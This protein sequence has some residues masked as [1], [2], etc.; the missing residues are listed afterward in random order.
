[1]PSSPSASLY[2]RLGQNYDSTRR[3]DPFIA[4]RLVHHLSNPRDG[5]ILDLACGTG[6]Y[7]IE[8]AKRGLIVTGVDNSERMIETASQKQSNVSWSLGDAE[9]LPFEDETFSGAICALAIHH[10][11]ALDKPFQEIFRVM[12]NGQFVIFTATSGQM[13][14]YWLNDYFPE[15]MRKSVDQMPGLD[16]VK[17]SLSQAGF[18]KI[19]TEIYEIQPDLRDRFLYSGKHNPGL[20]LDP[21]IR[22]GI[23][24][25]SNFANLDEVR[26]GC[27]RLEED[28]ISGAIQDVIKKFEHPNGDYLFVIPRKE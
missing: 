17:T 22:A 16:Q 4:S 14:G 3:A 9:A 28:I 23:S 13:K 7:S 8:L 18:G 27:L 15:A 5:K 2:D 1:M 26:R 20:Y 24:T 12:R 11:K 6:N 19:E 21:T 25:F 10:F